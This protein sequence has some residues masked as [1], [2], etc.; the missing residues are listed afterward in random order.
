MAR[1]GQQLAALRLAERHLSEQEEPT[2]FAPGAQRLQPLQAANY[3]LPIFYSLF[4]PQLGT[5]GQIHSIARSRSSA[6]PK[7]LEAG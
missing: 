5:K 3:F 7:E 1:R 2:P 4:H 6:G